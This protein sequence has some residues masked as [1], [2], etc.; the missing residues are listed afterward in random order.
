MSSKL[1]IP[2]KSLVEKY[3]K[4]LLNATLKEY[5]LESKDQYVKLWKMSPDNYK[6]EVDVIK[7]QIDSLKYDDRGLVFYVS[8]NFPKDKFYKDL[9]EKQKYKIF[10][11]FGY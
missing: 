6:K 11:F 10:K 9:R 7:K 1:K 8:K 2:P 5:G 3:K 4:S